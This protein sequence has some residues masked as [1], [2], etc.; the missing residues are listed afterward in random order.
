MKKCPHNQK[1]SAG[2]AGI[3]AMVLAIGEEAALNVLLNA[4]FDGIEEGL[5]GVQSALA[6]LRQALAVR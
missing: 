5:S 4:Y 1:G 6:L 2:P 3:D